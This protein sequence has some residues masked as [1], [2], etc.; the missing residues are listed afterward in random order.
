MAESIPNNSDNSETIEDNPAESPVAEP[1]ESA[2]KK[3]GRPKG[4]A[5]K[6]PR[7]P[8]KKAVVV[9][10]P[11][12]KEPEKPP[13]PEKTPEKPKRTRA[14]RPKTEAVAA[15]P[16]PTEAREPDPPSPRTTLRDA[17][18]HILQ[19]QSLRANTRRTHLADAYT[20]NLR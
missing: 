4:A 3:R 20:R 6:A 2:A 10:E 7:A 9:E 11:I 12:H 15:P 17:A 14:P 8:K 19:L 16:T 13:E 5:D 18:H 1:A